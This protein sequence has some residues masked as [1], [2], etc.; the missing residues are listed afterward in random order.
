VW[1]SELSLRRRELMESDLVRDVWYNHVVQDCSGLRHLCIDTTCDPAG[2]MRL[3][4]GQ[5]LSWQCL[6][7]QVDACKPIGSTDVRLVTCLSCSA[8]RGER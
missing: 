8:K 6:C 2:V 4:G 1:T 3:W 7:G 5:T